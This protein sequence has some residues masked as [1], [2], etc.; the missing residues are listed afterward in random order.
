M[1]SEIPTPVVPPDGSTVLC[2]RDSNHPTDQ[3]GRN[4]QFHGPP[5]IEHFENFVMATSEN[6]QFSLL[7]IFGHQHPPS[8]PHVRHW[9]VSVHLQG[10]VYLALTFLIKDGTHRD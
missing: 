3:R 10:Q 9:S 5:L 7:S 8:L 1:A 6:V 2:C 4:V